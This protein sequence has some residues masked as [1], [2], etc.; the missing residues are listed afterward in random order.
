L[1]QKHAG[2]DDEEIFAWIEELDGKLNS[3]LAMA[4]NS[5]IKTTNNSRENEIKKEKHVQ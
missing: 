3:V 1:L 5:E 4:C 2:I